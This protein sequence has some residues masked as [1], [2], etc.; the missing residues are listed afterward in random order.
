MIKFVLQ[1]ILG[2]K[3]YLYHFARYKIRT[4]HRD[5]KERDF[6]RFI[7]IIDKQG[8]ILDI[9][10][11]IGVMTW[12]LSKKFPERKIIA[13]EPEP[14]NL[15]VLHKII[16]NIQPDSVRRNIVVIPM[17]V[18][19]KEGNVQMV[20]PKKGKVKMQGLT[21]VVHESINEWNDGEKFDVQCT[22][23]DKMVGSEVIAAIKMDVENFEFNALLGAQNVL[24]KHHPPLYLELW[25]NENRKRCFDLLRQFGYEICVSEGE[26]LV[27]FIPGRYSDQNFICRFGG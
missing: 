14:T 26:K 25:D 16:G 17:A 8:V 6:F 23:L 11:N 10:A 13:V 22:T 15:E 20:L 19:E 1:S 4:L 24:E 2:Y 21:H 3:A 7:S 5:K 18:G 12:H 27:P 9:G